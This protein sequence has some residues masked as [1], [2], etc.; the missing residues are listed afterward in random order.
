MDILF[1]ALIFL[2]V[3]VLFV[4]AF[5]LLRT[6][7]FARPAEPVEPAGEPALEPEVIAGHV[8]TVLQCK[9]ISSDTKSASDRK[10]F[11]ELHHI[12]E[13]LYPR[14]HGGLEREFINEYSLLYT[15]K[16]SRPELEPVLLMAHLDVVPADPSTLNEWAHAPFSGDIAEGFV[17]GRGALD[18]KNQLVTI[19]EAVETLLKADYQPE[20]TVLLAF[21]H[22]EELGGVQG[23]REIAAHLEAQGV[24][25][26]AVI[27]EGGSIVEDLVPGVPVPIAMVGYAE[28]GYLT[29]E[30]NVEG[31]AGHSSTPPAH[32][33]IGVLARAVMRIEANPMPAH[34]S[35]V[36]SMFQAIGSAAPFYMQAAFANTWL[37]GG[38]VRRMMLASPSTA[39]TIRTTTAVTMVRGGIKDNVLPSEARALVNFRLLPGDTI[40]SVCERTRKVIADQRVKFSPLEDTAWEASPVSLTDTPAYRVLSRTVRQVFGNIPVAPYLVLG[41]TDSRHYASICDHVYRFS[42][43]SITTA[44]LA[45]MHG[46]NERIRVDALGQMVQFYMLLVGSWSKT[47]IK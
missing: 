38:V 31:Q 13:Q 43:V 7:T 9:T 41:A 26:A 6:V 16:G 4:V 12:L 20:R 2:L 11:F 24:H 46:V 28:K 27:D 22:D 25:L 3:L 19:L 17:W 5:V 8:S 32:S 1:T 33:A 45:R 44:D 15:W 29:L 10:A 18:I 35:M 36:R 39:A 42:P 30:L 47:E 21:G 34:I 37:M 40:A 23:T 14:V